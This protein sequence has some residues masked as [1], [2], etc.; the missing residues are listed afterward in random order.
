[1]KH[2]LLLIA[3]VLLFAVQAQ[4][5]LF[6]YDSDSL[7]I[8]AGTDTVLVFTPEWEQVSVQATDV[9]V[10]VMPSVRD[11]VDTSKAPFYLCD[12]CS[13][14]L[15]GGLVAIKSIRIYVAAGTDGI[16]R[17]LGVRKTN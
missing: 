8:A 13:I 5:Q 10:Y 2:I 15:G 12:M 17:F 4:G 7:A 14:D 11:T 1:M 16:V 9:S 6:N 3:F